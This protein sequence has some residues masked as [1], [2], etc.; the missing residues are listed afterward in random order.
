MFDHPDKISLDDMTPAQVAKRLNCTIALA[1]TMGD[2][3]D[4]L[5]GQS[6]VVF[7]PQLDLTLHVNQP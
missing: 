5:V 2:V 6:K 7:D 1:D 4:A 3:W